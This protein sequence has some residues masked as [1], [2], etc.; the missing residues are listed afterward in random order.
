MQTN[1][2][3]WRAKRA[4]GG[5]R[6]SDGEL[7]KRRKDA[8]FPRTLRCGSGAIGGTV[9]S[10]PQREFFVRTRCLRHEGRDRGHALR[11]S[12]DQSVR[13]E[14]EREDCSAKKEQACYWRSRPAVWCGMQIAGQLRCACE[15]WE[16]P[17]MWVCNIKEQT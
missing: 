12:G 8:V 17:P 7:R 5:S 15:C 2:P 11:D 6:L 9:S 13:R 16:S 1:R 10:N 14:V 3:C 4:R